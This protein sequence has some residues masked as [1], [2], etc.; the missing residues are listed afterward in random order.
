MAPPP[1]F[2]I[3]PPFS[4][5]QIYP[6]PLPS[7]FGRSYTSPL[8]IRRGWGG[9]QLCKYLYD[10]TFE[11]K[12]E[13][14]FFQL[15]WRKYINHISRFAMLNYFEEKSSLKS[16]SHLSKKICFIYFIKS[17]LEMMKNGFYFILKAL[18]V[19]K[20]FKFLSWLFGHTEKTAWLKRQ[21]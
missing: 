9:F 5:F 11:K 19:H 1:H 10:T 12:D 4:G 3:N 17:P 15:V 2:Y 18:L 21:S 8:L 6:S 14:Y 7:I 16:N 13:F 20:I